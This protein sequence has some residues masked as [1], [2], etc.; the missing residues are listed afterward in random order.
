MS[1][2]LPLTIINTDDK[3]KDTLWERLL[4][5]NH[6][7]EESFKKYTDSVEEELKNMKKEDVLWQKWRTLFPNKKEEEYNAFEIWKNST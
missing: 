2:K 6:L 5:F 1:N 7:S 3:N 4:T